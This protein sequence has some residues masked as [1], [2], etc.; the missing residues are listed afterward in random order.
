MAWGLVKDHWGK[1]NRSNAAIS[2]VIFTDIRPA[3]EF[4]KIFIQSKT[5]DNRT[6]LIGGDTWRVYARGPSNSSVAA[7]V[8]DHNN[9]TYEAL[10]FITEPGVYQLLIYLDYSLCDGFRDPPRDWFIKGNAQGDYHRNGIL[11]YL[12]DYL[13]QPFKNGQPLNITILKAQLKISLLDKLDDLDACSHNC[14]H[15]WDGFGQWD[16]NQ[17]RPHLEESYNWSMP[18]NYTQSGTLW[19]SGD[20]LGLLLARSVRSRTLCKSLYKQ[21]KNTYMY[22]YIVGDKEIAKLKKDDRDFRPEK[23]LETIVSVLRRPEMQ[24]EGSAMLLNIVIHFIKNVNFTTYQS[25]IDDLIQALKETEVNSQGQR[26]PKYKAKIIWKSSTAIRKENAEFLNVTARR[27]MT[28]QRVA[29]FSA[30]SMSAMCKAGF[31]VIDVHPLTD[32]NPRGPY[33]Q[34]HYPKEVFDMLE[35]ML[36]QYKVN[37]NKRLDENERNGK[38]KRCISKEKF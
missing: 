2:D 29:L 35:R 33:D 27:F 20:S 14:K 15:L 10:L 18:Q 21:C 17:W 5:S 26:V 38:I 8:F 19:I 3:G 32:S 7:T 6:K 24:E 28:T 37:Y 31:D 36:E 9:G 12:D 11:G 22:T 25:L 30:Y 34:V 4:S 13:I 1:I 23:V 16:N